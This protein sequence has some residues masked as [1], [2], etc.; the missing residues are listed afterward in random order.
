[1][2]KLPVKA[3]K[4]LDFLQSSAARS[5]RVQC[6][7]VEPG[8]RL[9]TNEISNTV[10]FFGSAR[11]KAPE[12]AAREL[13]TAQQ[14]ATTDDSPAAKAALELAERNNKMARYYKDAMELAKRLTE[15]S[16][17]N[18]AAPD[19]FNV[20]TGGGP[21]IMEAANRGA[22]LGGGKSIGMN[23]SLPFEQ[24][25]NGFQNPEL[26]FEFHYF[27]VRKFWLFHPAK[28]LIVFPGGFGTFDEMF[29][30]LTLIQTEKTDGYLPIVLYGTEY[31]NEVM[32][33][34]A[35]VKWGT[36][37]AA[38]IHLMSKFDEV[39]AAFDFLT[40]ELDRCYS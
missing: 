36:I 7:L 1:M 25:P 20:C 15:W 22:Q 10:V 5:I 32:N 17:E 29:E 33:L 37:A 34:D 21:G 9:K 40:A 6:E 11:T 27:F 19:R 12:E 4:N 30:L 24:S 18:H 23:I 38:D 28:A 16:V 13:R 26:C 8:E 31:W 2:T 14:Q 3:Y 39:D 35:M